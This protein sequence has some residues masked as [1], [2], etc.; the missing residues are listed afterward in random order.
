MTR[1]RRISALIAFAVTGFAFYSTG[2]L[3]AEKHLVL[4]N[5]TNET[6]TTVQADNGELDIEISAPVQ[7]GAGESGDVVFDV[8]EGACMFNLHYVLQS[9]NI[10][11]QPNVDLCSTDGVIVE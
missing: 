10:I 4:Q 5:H 9:A 1:V 2:A 7:M 11:N 3:A 6:I 8:P